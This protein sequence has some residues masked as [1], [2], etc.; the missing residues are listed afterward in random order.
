M[1]QKI[2]LGVT[3]SIAAY[4]AADLAS[5]LTQK[6]FKL[7]TVLTHEAQKFVGAATF[8][9][10]TGRP[11]YQSA[12]TEDHSKILHIDLAEESDLIVIAPATAHMVAKLAQGL[13]DDLLSSTALACTKPIVVVPVMN[14]NMYQHPATQANLK[15]LKTRG[16]QVMDPDSGHMACGV[17]GVG[18]YPENSKII[19]TIE[20]ILV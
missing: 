17:D 14:P 5:Q 7:S 13:A 8:G 16:V 10:V 4:K 11:V 15:T 19:E 12:Y 20:K 1:A 18:R 6:G 2:L 3:G 9:G